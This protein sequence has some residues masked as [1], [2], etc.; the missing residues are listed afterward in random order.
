[1]WLRTMPV[2][3]GL[4]F[5][6]IVRFESTND[7]ER[8][9][10]SIETPMPPALLIDHGPITYGFAVVPLP[11]V[12]HRQLVKSLSETITIGACAGLDPARA[13]AA[14]IAPVASATATRHFRYLRMRTPRA[15]PYCKGPAAR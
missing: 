5:P 9:V 1:M 13:V 4:A 6:A 8:F 11:D 12:T 14:P 2:S 7:L 3:V 10:P 15:A